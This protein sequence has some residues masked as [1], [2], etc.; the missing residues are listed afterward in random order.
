VN[1]EALR[2]PESFRGWVPGLSTPTGQV[3][4]PRANAAGRNEHLGEDT[5]PTRAPMMRKWRPAWAVMAPAL[6][7][8]AA[9]RITLE[10][11]EE[12]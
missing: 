2:A 4:P 9:A 5:C 8:A 10:H 3:Q 6:N 11:P 12:P 1:G 7:P